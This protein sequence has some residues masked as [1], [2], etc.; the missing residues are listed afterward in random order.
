MN[1]QN[2]RQVNE[3]FPAYRHRRREAAKLI[4]RYLARG[5]PATHSRE[6]DRD[7]EPRAYVPGPQP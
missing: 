2:H 4:E 5:T 7:G 1:I 6:R 3:S